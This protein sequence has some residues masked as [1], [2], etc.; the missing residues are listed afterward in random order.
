MHALHLSMLAASNLQ[1]NVDLYN[2]FLF[3]QICFM[4]IPNHLFFSVTNTIYMYSSLGVGD[5]RNA[6]IYPHVIS[7]KFDTTKF[8]QFLHP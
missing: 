3:L 5:N 4:I 6:F 7:L 8:P 1:S 2:L